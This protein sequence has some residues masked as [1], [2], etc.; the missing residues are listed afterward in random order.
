LNKNNNTATPIDDGKCDHLL[1][2]QLPKL[3]LVST[4]NTNIDLSKLK[5]L[6]VF[7][8]YPR[9]GRPDV[10]LPSGWGDIVGASGCTPQSCSFKDYHKEFD[11][12]DVTVYGVSTQSSDYQKEA[13]DRLSLPFAVLSDENLKLSEALNLPTFEVE[14]VVLNKRVT[15]ICQDTKI[16][17]V[18]YPVFPPKEN[19]AD[20]ISYIK[21]I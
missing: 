14:G 21:K 16:I 1:N 10:E 20:V 11:E 12:L 8:F 18:F 3:S 19:A 17:K 6:S 7:Y 15:L 2:M 13:V 4:N 9:M 5:G